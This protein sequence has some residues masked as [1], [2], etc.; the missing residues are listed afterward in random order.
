MDVAVGAM[1]LARGPMDESFSSSPPRFKPKAAGMTSSRSVALASSNVV[2][3]LAIECRP[4]A[5]TRNSPSIPALRA[6]R[7]AT[8]GGSRRGLRYC[9]RTIN[10]RVVGRPA[11]TRNSPSI[12]VLRTGPLAGWLAPLS[13]P[14][15]ER[16]AQ[17]V[18][19]EIERQHQQKNG[20]T[21][22]YRHPRCIVDVILGGIEHASPGR[23]RRLLAKAQK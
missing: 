3:I 9:Q 8:P 5:S 6:G 14:G 15:I 10:G 16:V 7:L 1:P 13:M 18:A 20:Q 11:S 23:R 17:A 19:D 4:H 12:P 21:G 22:P 2:A